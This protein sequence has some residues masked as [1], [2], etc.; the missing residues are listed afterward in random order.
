MKAV[1][2]FLCFICFTSCLTNAQ[3]YKH[4]TEAEIAALTPAQ[5]V[6]EW[7]NEVVRHE[8][9]WETDKQDEL[10]KKYLLLDGMKTVPRLTEIIEEYDPTQFPEGKGRRGKR[11]DAGVEMLYFIDNFS[12]RLRSAE[13]GRKAIDALERSIERMRKIGYGKDPNESYARYDRVLDAES[14][15]KD[16]KGTNF[17]DE[18][19]KETLKVIYKITL[20]DKELLEFTNFLTV[21]YPE[22]PSWSKRKNY[23][24][25]EQLNSAGY[26][27]QFYIFVTPERHYKAYSE[28][29]KMK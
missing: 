5:R 7:V 18:D 4:K 9:Y 16:A 3:T 22:Y 29:E 25:K 24:D 14:K 15:L 26:P 8:K 28:F 13:E 2:I 20:T 19:L 6:D 10:I 23:V 27:L 21:R 12:I 11:F 1:I 17:T